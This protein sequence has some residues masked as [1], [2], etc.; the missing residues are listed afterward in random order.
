MRLALGALVLLPPLVLSPTAQ[1]NF[2]LPKLLASEMLGL[3][4]VIA[5][6][7]RLGV[8]E[9]IDW[10]SLLS[11]PVIRLVGPPLLVATSTL[12]TTSH[13][14]QVR[15]NIASVWIGSA[16]LVACSLGLAR[17]E[18]ERLGR[19]LLGAALF[20][21]LLGI[22]QA[23]VYNPFAFQGQVSERI[24]LTSL[25][26][27]PFDLAAY[28]LLPCL[29]AQ[30]LIYR[31]SSLRQRVLLGLALLIFLL[32]MALGQT[33]TVLIALASG[34]WLLWFLLLP[35]QR[36]LRAALAVGVLAC[37]LVLGVEPLRVRVAAKAASLKNGNWNQLLTGRL[38]GWRA[39]GWMLA[40]HPVV[41]VGQGA[42]RAEFGRAK[43][44]LTAEG[45]EFDPDLREVY[46]VNAHSDLLEAVAEWGSLGILALLWAGWLLL[47]RARVRARQLASGVPP[48]PAAGA[49]L[50]SGL[51]AMAVLSAS[52]FPF[53]LA[54][55]AYPWLLFLSWVF[56]GD[57]PSR[58]AER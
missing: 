34:S 48:D 35:R 24:R 10:R 42:Y 57:Q 28:L 29:L 12:F 25:A 7:P 9:R 11:L 40:Q 6:L 51:L 22:F 5:L 27:G 43:L 2:R 8:L 53:H 38:D 44:A 23:L 3:L 50:W 49:L 56:A 21:A 14:L 30:A 41:G 47:Q 52:N 58:T 32:A 33:L 54:L 46:F 37:A 1:D 39:A 36:F 15:A 19:L 17:R 13:P 18:L 55:V 16:L 31:T 45:V 20:L 26:G 4:V